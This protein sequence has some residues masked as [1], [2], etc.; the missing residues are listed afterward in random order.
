MRAV[1]REVKELNQEVLGSL[2][3]SCNG[4][5]PARFLDLQ[6][7][8]AGIDARAFTA[9]FPNTCCTGFYAMGEIGPQ[10][11]WT[12]QAVQA[13]H[14]HQPQQLQQQGQVSPSLALS[15]TGSSALQGF[16]AVFAVLCVPKR[17]PNHGSDLLGVLQRQGTA[18][19]LASMLGGKG[20]GGPQASAL[21]GTGSSMDS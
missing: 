1:A 20:K 5:G 10:S 17:G 8:A 9:A 15:Q 14:Q 13:H 7:A 4:R 16:T 11:I 19:A 21:G 2:L 18:A 3:F 12:E 6:G